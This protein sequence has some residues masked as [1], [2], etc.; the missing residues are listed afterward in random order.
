[1]LLPRSQSAIRWVLVIAFAAVSSLN[2]WAQNATSTLPQTPQPIL[3][4]AVQ[5][6]HY[7]PV[8]YSKSVSQFPNVIGPYKPRY[9]PPPNL[10]NTDR[11][12][13]LMHEGKIML[14]M[15]DAVALALEN[16]LDL[17]LARVIT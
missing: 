3:A 5:P 1:M 16:N 8:D 2:A 10:N 11:I 17:V 14:S 7:T 6:E 13:Q 4:P 9:V 15:N 12:Q